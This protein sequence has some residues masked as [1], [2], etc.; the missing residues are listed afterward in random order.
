MSTLRVN[1]LQEVDGT[2]FSRI[3]Q[4]VSTK[5]TAASSF[6]LGGHTVD[7][8]ITAL[9][10]T[11]TS[12][13]ANSSFIYSCQVFCEIDGA[14]HDFAVNLGREIGGS[15]TKYARGDANG[16]N[17][18][19]T[20]MIPPAFYNNDQDSTPTCI[21]I[22]PLVD[23]PAQAASTAIKYRIN[24]QAMIS[25]SYNFFLNRTVNGTTNQSYER[26]CSYVTI[27]ELAV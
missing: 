6:A 25:G 16:S 13:L 11:I 7:T 2:P 3:V 26:G 18:R 19:I 23:S 1:T 22:S 21:N 4:V 12:K 14:D 27:M 15:E 24:I 20:R 9:D 17:D 8:P 10:T 5:V